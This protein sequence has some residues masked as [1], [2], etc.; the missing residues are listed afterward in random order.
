MKY[1]YGFDEESIPFGIKALFW[2]LY[3]VVVFYAVWKV[4]L[5]APKDKRNVKVGKLFM[6]FFAGYA[7]F[8]CVNPDYFNYR[9]WMEFTFYDWNKER[10]YPYIVVFCRSLPFGYP[11]EMFRLVVWGGAL[12]LVFRLVRLYRSLLMPGLAVLLLFVFYSGTFC[13]ARASLAMAVFFMGIGIHLWAKGPRD[14]ILGM[15]LAIC[16]YYFHHEMIIAIVL[17]PSIL[18]P[19]EKKGTGIL[20]LVLLAIAVVVFS[21]INSSPDLMETIFGDDNLAE[22]IEQYSEQEQGAFRMSTLVKYLNIFYPFFLITKVFRRQINLPGAM[23]G[24]YRITYA[25]LLATMAFF[26]VSG[27]RSVYT[28]RV[29]YIM[30]IPVSILVTYCYNQGF[31]KKHQIVIMLVLAVLTNSVRLINSI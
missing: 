8:Y 3:M 2:G 1:F 20:S 13:Y 6:L 21:H 25:L 10:I 7:V 9:E 18:L 16:S 29:M 19:F 22:Q 4:K 17:L 23:A 24:I 5:A 28:Y 30:I 27:S 31:L 15:A 14:K 26:V 12:L 11:Y